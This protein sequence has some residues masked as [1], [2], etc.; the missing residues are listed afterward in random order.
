MPERFPE[1]VRRLLD[2]IDSVAQL[3][4][5]LLL[6]RSAPDSWSARQLGEELRIEPAWAAEQLGILCDRGL[7]AATEDCE[8]LFHY[9]PATAE[10]EKAVMALAAY[11]EAQR[12]AV[13]AFLY[14]KPTDRIRTFADAF[15]IRREDDDG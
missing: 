3:E 7:L 10:L 11:Y 14:S 6:Y 4:V 12:V 9:Q 2:R 1:G 5:L 15:R 13:I 8:G